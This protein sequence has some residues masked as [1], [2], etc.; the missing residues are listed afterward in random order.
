MSTSKSSDNL[1]SCQNTT[2]NSVIACALPNVTI[3]NAAPALAT[4]VEPT[5]ESANARKLPRRRTTK[6]KPTTRSSTRRRKPKEDGQPPAVLCGDGFEGEEVSEIWEDFSDTDN[7][8]QGMENGS[9]TDES[10][11]E[12]ENELAEQMFSHQQVGNILHL[13][14]FENQ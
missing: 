6:R 5:P 4:R 1:S 10:D 9:S 7:E 14:E 12:F 11:I 8:N 13:I 2:S 3:K